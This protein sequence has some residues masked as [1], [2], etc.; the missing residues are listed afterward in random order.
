MNA[1]TDA[2]IGDTVY[3]K[4]TTRTAP[5]ECYLGLAVRLL[6]V[7]FWPR[8]DVLLPDGRHMVLHRLNVVLHP[9]GFTLKK[10]GD[11]ANQVEMEMV[12]KPAFR[13]HKPLSDGDWEEP[14]LF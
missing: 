4:P 11:G 9:P 8:V 7:E 1:Q 12:V 10:Q 5:R 13:P 6:S 14:M 2:E 3:L